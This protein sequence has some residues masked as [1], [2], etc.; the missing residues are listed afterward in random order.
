MSHNTMLA[1]SVMIDP[2]EDQSIFDQYPPK[3]LDQIDYSGFGPDELNS[4]NGIKELMDRATKE[5]NISFEDIS[6]YMA[7]VFCWI[8]RNPGN[9][10]NYSQYALA[11]DEAMAN[12]MIS[13][14]HK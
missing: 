5:R 1:V 14:F 10:T 2:N 6:F 4:V 13:N 12:T 9:A 11:L 3:P 8:L 7:E